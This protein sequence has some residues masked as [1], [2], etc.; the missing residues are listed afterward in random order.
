MSKIVSPFAEDI[1]LPILPHCI[2]RIYHS[3]LHQPV[4]SYDKGVFLGVFSII[5]RSL[6]TGKL[7]INNYY[8]A[9]RR[10][11]WCTL[12]FGLWAQNNSALLET[13]IRCNASYYETS[14]QLFHYRSPHRSQKQK[15]NSNADGFWGIKKAPLTLCLQ[16]SFTPAH[17]FFQYLLAHSW[18]ENQPVN[19]THKPSSQVSKPSAIFLQHLTK[20]AS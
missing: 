5:W 13:W 2:P 4:E 15:G 11:A 10:S 6:R 18:I 12:H 17:N 8:C 19:R 1:L 20:A 16:C 14:L 3:C 9:E 7:H